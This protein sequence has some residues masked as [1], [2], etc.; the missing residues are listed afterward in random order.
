MVANNIINTLLICPNLPLLI[1][2]RRSIWI[3]CSKSDAKLY[4]EKSLGF[5]DSQTQV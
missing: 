4:I 2:H 3:G 5:Q 1:L